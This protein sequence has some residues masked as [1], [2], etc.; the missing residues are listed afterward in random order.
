MASA[1]FVL[2]VFLKIGKGDLGVKGGVYFYFTFS[3]ETVGG[4]L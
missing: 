2:P 4:F 3:L 1:L